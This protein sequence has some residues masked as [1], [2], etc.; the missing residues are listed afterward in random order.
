MVKYI[1]YQYS[2]HCG[3]LGDF[4]K[5]F[6]HA[7]EIAQQYH[8][9]LLVWIE[10][11]MAKYVII[12][13]REMLFQHDKTYQ[14][15]YKPISQMMREPC[16]A[17]MI[18]PADFYATCFL[19]CSF[20]N[21]RVFPL[22]DYF[23]FHHHVYN[24]ADNRMTSTFDSIHVRCGDKHLELVPS[25]NI[26]PHDDRTPADTSRLI[27]HILHEQAQDGRALVLFTDNNHLKR[28]VKREFPQVTVFEDTLVHTGLRYSDRQLFHD[29]LVNTLVDFVL[30]S[31]S[32]T[33]YVTSNSGFPWMAHLFSNRSD[34]TV[35]D[36]SGF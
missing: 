3:G 2:H 27:S 24:I 26:C 13:Q 4:F 5:F 19:P 28:T 29:G 20:P 23:A 6:I 12:K 8:T 11:P 17:V 32:E 21:A 34:Q 7:H 1:L 16:D 9:P 15:V 36:L 25:W 14:Q 30:L 31:R 18:R 35:V 33:I 10:H 22:Y